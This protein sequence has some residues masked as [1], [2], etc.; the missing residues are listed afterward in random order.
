MR[1]LNPVLAGGDGRFGAQAATVKLGVVGVFAGV[2]YLIVRKFPRTASAF[3]KINWAGAAL[4][5]SFAVHNYAI[6]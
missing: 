5:S 6:R 1:E 3:A 4:T 2:Q